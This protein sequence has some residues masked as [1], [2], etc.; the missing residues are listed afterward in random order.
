[1]L[2]LVKGKASKID[3]GVLLLKILVDLIRRKKRLSKDVNLS[4]ST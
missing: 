4:G 2:T 1:M 3:Q